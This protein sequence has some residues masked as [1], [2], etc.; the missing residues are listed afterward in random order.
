MFEDTPGK[1]IKWLLV[2]LLATFVIGIIFA[3][4]TTVVSYMHLTNVIY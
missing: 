3:T 1:I 4:L 2:I